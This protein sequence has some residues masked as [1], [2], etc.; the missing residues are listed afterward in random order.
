[1]TADT[2]AIANTL[3]PTIQTTK[4]ALPQSAKRVRAL[5]KRVRKRLPRFRRKRVLLVNKRYEVD[6]LVVLENFGGRHGEPGHGKMD[7]L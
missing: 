2:A 3:L 5:V 6:L 7:D 1:M 4:H